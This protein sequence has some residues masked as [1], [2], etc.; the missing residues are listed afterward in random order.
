MRALALGLCLAL[1]S[2]F[3][4]CADDPF[5]S[6]PAPSPDPFRSAPEQPAPRPTPRPRPAP[7]PEPIEATPPP[8][9]A[10]AVPAPAPPAIVRNGVW[11]VTGRSVGSGCGYWS[12]RITADNNKLSGYVSVGSGTLNFQQMTLHS[13]GTFSGSTPGGIGE[14]NGFTNAKLPIYSISGKLS[15]DILTVSF[16]VANTNCTLPRTGEG[17]RIGS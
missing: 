13:D 12:I 16:T 10:V 17:K 7:S 5:Q 6:A 8:Q 11:E 4:A 2:P 3:L 15:D 14:W 9:R 1:G